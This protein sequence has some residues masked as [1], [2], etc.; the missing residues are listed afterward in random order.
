MNKVLNDQNYSE[1]LGSTF[2]FLFEPNLIQ[3]ID[4]CSQKRTFEAGKTIMDIGNDITHMPLII[5]GSIKV[6]TVDEDQN[7]LLLYYLEFGETCSVTLNCSSK[8]TT[9]T[10]KAVTEEETEVLFI[11]ID[12]MEKWMINYKSWRSFVLESYHTR[13][14]EMVHAIDML[15]FKSLEERLLKYLTDKSMVNNNPILMISHRI[16]AKEMNSSRVVISRLMKKL[17]QKN[18]LKQGRNMIEILDFTK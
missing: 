17:E 7:D 4:H 15:V 5:S 8:K 3:E 16:I 1:T 12:R 13:M 9:S 11:P 14:N 2:K 18:R 10:I 6:M